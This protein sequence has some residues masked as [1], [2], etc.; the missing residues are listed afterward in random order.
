MTDQWNE[1]LRCPQCHKTGMAGLSQ[2]KGAQ[3][4]TVDLVPAGFKVVQSQY[5]PDFHCGTCD[6][7]VLP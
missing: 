7:P 3:V 2:I 1:N 4:P 6:V 5:G